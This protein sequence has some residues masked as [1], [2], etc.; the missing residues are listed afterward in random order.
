MSWLTKHR[1]RRVFHLEQLP[2]CSSLLIISQ[3]SPFAACKTRVRP[4]SKRAT[5]WL[6]DFH[7]RP[8]EMSWKQASR[9]MKLKEETIDFI[10]RALFPFPLKC[11]GSESQKRAVR[12]CKI[13]LA[14]SLACNQ[15]A[16][17]KKSEK[18]RDEKSW[19]ELISL[20][21]VLCCSLLW[22]LLYSTISDKNDWMLGLL[23]CLTP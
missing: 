6:E 22:D 5:S 18:A 17:R 2:S 4:A 9:M 19:I 20:I 10:V 1:H 16:K 21:F 14:R 23:L 12:R 11:I 13:W 7:V 3:L 8:A 15:R